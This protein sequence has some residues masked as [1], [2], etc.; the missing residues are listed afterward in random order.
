M[1]VCRLNQCVLVQVFQKIEKKLTAGSHN[2]E[3]GAPCIGLCYECQC[4]VIWPF[5]GLRVMNTQQAAE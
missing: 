3:Q 2:F 4:S 5:R 1:A